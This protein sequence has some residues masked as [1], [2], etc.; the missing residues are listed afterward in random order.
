MNEPRHVVSRRE[1]LRTGGGFALGGMLAL[2]ADLGPAMARTRTLKI[3]GATEV[4]SICPY[5]AV[6]CGTIL[7]VM[8]GKL[9]NVEGNPDS[10]ISRGSLCPKGA[11]SFQLAVNPLRTTKVKYRAPGAADWEE[12]PL[13]WAMER[14]AQ[15]VKETRDANFVETVTSKDKEGKD[16]AKRVNHTQAIASLGGATMDNEWNYA[17]LKLMR[18]LGVIWIENQARI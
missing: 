4:P 8:N 3:E 16:V 1:F 18:A 12:R 9:I 7:S 2:G 17:Q 15:L 6:G 11:A 13:D 5:C 10:P 14:I